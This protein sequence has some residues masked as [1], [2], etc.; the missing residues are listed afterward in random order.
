[1]SSA[2][3][4]AEAGTRSPPCCL[5]A[6]P[7]QPARLPSPTAGTSTHL[8]LV[9]LQDALHLLLLLP[10]LRVLTP[11]AL[12]QHLL[13][14]LHLAGQEGVGADNASADPSAKQQQCSGAAVHGLLTQGPVT[15]Y[16]P[17][18]QL[19]GLPHL[20]HHPLL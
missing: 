1:M 19:R 11:L 7:P 8:A 20:P 10:P 2:G 15:P 9:L 17:R 4:T 14:H 6:A 3:M 13:L 5:P 18:H 16:C 12:Q